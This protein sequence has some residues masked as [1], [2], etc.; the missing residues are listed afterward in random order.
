MTECHV[1]V[2]VCSNYPEWAVF[3]GECSTGEN[4]ITPGLYAMVGATAVLAGITRMT[5]QWS[6]AYIT[7]MTGQWWAAYI[8]RMTGQWRAAYI[9]TVGTVY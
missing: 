9:T 1:C 8:T 2:Y 5:G 4:C 6:A 3:A 7:R